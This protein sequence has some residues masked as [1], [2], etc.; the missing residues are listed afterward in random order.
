VLASRARMGVS[1]GE[2]SGLRFDT[3]P[4]SGGIRA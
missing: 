3:Y 2:L 4:W 1:D